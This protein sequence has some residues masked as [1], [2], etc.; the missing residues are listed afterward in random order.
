MEA[1]A[2]ALLQD[3]VPDTRARSARV[4]AFSN[5]VEPK[6]IARD[7]RKSWIF[8]NFGSGLDR[9]ATLGYELA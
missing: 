2:F 3:A 6:D 5:L 9:R 8:D 7:L 1:N 4:F